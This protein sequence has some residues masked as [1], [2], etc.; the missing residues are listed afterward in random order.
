MNYDWSELAFASKKR[1]NDLKA[2]FI[3]APRELSE[4]RFKEI[5][6]AY[7]PHGNL[8]LGLAKE[9]YVDGFE[10]QP[11]F[12]ML[13]ME[14]VSSTIRLVDKSASKNKLA[15]L[16]YFQRELPF[17]LE[18][19]SFRHVV[20]VNGSWK[21]S[22]HL[23]PEY[24]VLVR[25]K[26]S[27]E[28]ISPFTSEEEARVYAADF[29]KTLHAAKV[30]KSFSEAAM[31]ALADNV[32]KNSFDYSFQI[33]A[34][35]GKKVGSGYK[36]L[37]TG[38]NRVVPYQTYAMHFGS[39]RERHFSPPGD[40]SYYDTVHAETDLLITCLKQKIDLAETSLFINVLP[41]PT[42]G[43]NL[44]RT[45]IADVIYSLDHTDGYSL[46]LLEAAGKTVKRIASVS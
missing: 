35:L 13:N 2:T 3:I 21:L 34:V 22:F 5:V 42:C 15:T 14:T 39:S 29:E 7:L 24:Y 30:G 36:L 27:Y 40:L 1:V 25:Q 46:R 31:M 9:K 43:R 44:S 38:F 12:Q 10:N 32:A 4:S 18:K 8:V 37:A 45:G 41:C 17:V 28:L 23:R 6:K 33:G 11:Q 26:K 20:G 16:S 19:L